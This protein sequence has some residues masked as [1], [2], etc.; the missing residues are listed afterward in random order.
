MADTTL[1]EARRCPKC[2]EL[3]I[4]SSEKRERNGSRLL[5]FMCRNG[6]CKWNEQT[7][8]IVE[9]RP[10]GTI[11]EARMRR[12]KSFP[13]LGGDQTSRVRE[14]IDRQLNAEYRNAEV[15]R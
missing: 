3:G 15:Q 1:D 14:T 5:T 9:V 7:C 10:D 2:K 4:K 12:S 8:R 11:P 6:R 13:S